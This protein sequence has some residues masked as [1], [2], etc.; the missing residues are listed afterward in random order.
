MSSFLLSPV[1]T[2]DE[3]VDF[4]VQHYFTPEE[5]GEAQRLIEAGKCYEE[6]IAFLVGRGQD[7]LRNSGEERPPH[8]F[9]TIPGGTVFVYHPQRHFPQRPVLK[10]HVGHLASRI[11]PRP[12]MTVPPTPDDHPAQATGNRYQHFSL[13]VDV[14]VDPAGG[15][16]AEKTKRAGTRTKKLK[17]VEQPVRMG[18]GRVWRERPG[19]VVK[20]GFL[21]YVIQALKPDFFEVG[22]VHLKSNHVMATVYLHVLDE[23]TH[24]RV[25]G[26]VADALQLT[27]WSRGIAAILKEKTGEQKKGAW[28]RELE[29]LWNRH[30]LRRY[31]LSLFHTETRA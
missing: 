17:F 1:C 12:S 25:Q 8:L 23:S 5:L 10:C 14:P 21:G 9:I 18:S 29:G 11:L 31:Q 28:A 2:D 20:E 24:E 16:N 19:W 7:T 22:L 27:D 3:V 15:E 26:W 6:A 30:R 4:A 13:F